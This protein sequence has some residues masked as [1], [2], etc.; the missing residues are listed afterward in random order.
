MD[1]LIELAVLLFII[2]FIAYWVIQLIASILFIFGVA[3]LY[4]SWIVVPVWAYWLL[5]ERAW[6]LRIRAGVLKR[7]TR[8][9]FRNGAFIPVFRADLEHHLRRRNPRELVISLCLLAWSLTFGVIAVDIVDISVGTLRSSAGFLDKASAL[10]DIILVLLTLLFAGMGLL[11]LPSGDNS[12]ERAVSAGG[13]WLDG[14]KRA[15]SAFSVLVPCYQ[16]VAKWSRQLDIT[17]PLTHDHLQTRL[18]KQLAVLGENPSKRMILFDRECD[19]AYR[20]Y[21]EL[22]ACA[23]M[24]E[25]L[26]RAL[27]ENT[28][29]SE[30]QCRRRLAKGRRFLVHLD[31]KGYRNWARRQLQQ[32]GTRGETGSAGPPS[33]A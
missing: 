13:D 22:E 23:A 5:W 15:L 31:W 10:G 12:I 19:R 18:Q 17:P 30:E 16:E 3:L 4:A 24:Q 7:F 8:V 25:G 9:T 6:P 27:R 32:D 26:Y 11:F 21:R 1:E 14:V 29:L 20:L 33:G 28:P 2:G